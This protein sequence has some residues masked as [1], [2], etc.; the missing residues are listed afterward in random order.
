MQPEPP[1]LV[2]RTGRAFW[3]ETGTPEHIVA[4]LQGFR[5]G[6]FR[7][8]WFFDST[9]GGW[10]ILE[11]TLKQRPS[12]I[13]QVLPWK[14]LAVELRLG[15]RMDMDLEAV[16]SQLAVILRSDNDF[17]ESLRTPPAEVLARFQRARTPV[18]L[19]TIASEYDR[20]A[21]SSRIP[22]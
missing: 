8:A 11:A 3:V 6:C 9:G 12:F 7:E 18:D 22:R 4:T 19:I 14:R 1:F 15:S 16:V 21:V 17:C 5:E 2:V 10:P 20:H 13:H